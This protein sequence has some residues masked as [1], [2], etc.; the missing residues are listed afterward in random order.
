MR[1]RAFTVSAALMAALALT[2][3]AVASPAGHH[4]GRR[5]DQPYSGFAPADTVLRQGSP[6]SAGLDSAPIQAFEKQLTSWE[7]PASGAGYLFPGATALMAHDGVVVER[8]AGGYAVKY[9]NT[10]TLLPQD[11][12]VP[13]RT[14]TI[15]DLASLSKLFTSIVAVQQIDA[16][17]IDLDA[18]VAQYLPEFATNGKDAITIEQLLTHTSG[19]PADPSPSLWAG[20]SDIP[21]R[22]KAILDAKPQYPAGSTYL[23]SDLNML[24]MQL[25]LQQVTGKPLDELVRQGITEPLHMVDTGYNPPAS[26]LPRIA[27]TEYETS[28]ARG[29]V[30]GSVHDENAWAMNGVAGHAGVFSTV[31]DLAVLCQAILNG[32]AYGGHRILSRHGVELMEQNFN[33]NYP[34]NSHGLGFELDLIWYMGGLSG[35]TTL[36]HTGFTGTSLVIDPKSRS[37]AILLTNRVHPTRNTPS[38]NPARRGIAGALAQAIPVRAPGHG[39]SWYSGQGGG[40]TSTLTTS[41]PLTS[42]GPLSVDFSTFV[43]TESTDRVYLE[44]SADGGTTWT[45]V[46]LQVQGTGAP[47]GSPTW[48][49]GQAVRAWWHVHAEVPQAANGVLLRWRYTT[50]PV[51]EG[52]GVN[53]AHLRVADGDNVLLDSD[54]GGAGLTDVGWQAQPDAAH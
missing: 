45:P 30:R 19:L 7:N 16:G 52:R 3:S 32:G 46:P 10:S 6:A 44:S 24:T 33:Q 21:S 9:Q 25:V 43:N 39:P 14:D 12:W 42:S 37:F 51:Y 38:T 29:M 49:S 36:G 27:A 22:E 34:G 20:Y 31:D 40:T 47:T 50:D 35:P 4:E 28:P 17:K 48:L 54:K 8:S 1:T 11:Q 18:P 13:A 2:G 15:Y 23:Y 5:F 53:L 26:K 41:A